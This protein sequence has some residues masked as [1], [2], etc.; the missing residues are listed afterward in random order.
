MKKMFFYAAAAIVAFASCS[1]NE[2][3]DTP[4]INT[5]NEPAISFQMGSS[6]EVTTRGT[7]AV[8]GSTEETNVWNSQK[9]NVYMFEQ[10]KMDLAYNQTTQ[11]YYFENAEVIAPDSVTSGVAT[12][13]TTQY[14]P[15]T[16]NFDFFAY[17]ADGAN[18]V[19]PALNAT[20][21]AYIV[22]VEI[23]GTQDLMVSKAWLNK[24]DSTTYESQAKFDYERVYSAYSARREVQPRFT[25][26][27]LLS[28]FVFQAEAM[29]EGAAGV[30][31]IKITKVEVKAPVKGNMTVAALDEAAL[32]VTFGTT[33]ADSADLVLTN[34]GAAMTMDSLIYGKKVVLGES[35]LLPAGGTEYVASISYEQVKVDTVT[36][37]ETT[38]KD[39][40]T[41]PITLK[42]NAAFVAGTQYNV[43][44]KVYDFKSIVLT[45]NLTAWKEGE[46]VNLDSEE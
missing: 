32:G 1:Q 12:Y 26:N 3:V 28:R 17:H 46:D 23:D 20:E 42:N 30:N 18:I 44:I 40:F 33:A 31:G 13:G 14:Y 39:V 22:E 16:G 5:S 35:M 8:G 6:F 43:N 11:T 24:A 2:G 7:G 38:I 34:R 10:G 9:L 4:T 37:V 19:A 36:N 15:S 29:E 25:F 41:A 21:D 45:A 27:H